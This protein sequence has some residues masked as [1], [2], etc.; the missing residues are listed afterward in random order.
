M[1]FDEYRK[2][3]LKVNDKDKFDIRNSY[4]TR[5][6]YRWCIKNRKI[7]RNISER[8]F[9]TIINTINQAIADEILKGRIVKLPVS[10][11]R[12][13]LAKEEK[14][15]RVK[16]DG[17]LTFMPINWYETLKLW[18]ED[19]EAEKNKTLV[20]FEVKEV[21]EI[22]YDVRKAKYNNKTYFKFTPMR[23]LKLRLKKEAN[24][25]NIDALLKYRNYGIHKCR[26]SNGQ[27]H[28]TPSSEGHAL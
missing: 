12:L 26:K 1:R 13:F 10:M 17:N 22:Y 9:R 18:H 23:D 28:K 21:Y 8:D 16:E 4:G 19:E 6:I 3:V 24:N 11:G 20:K 2:K 5:D 7:D 27:N 14:E 15:M 25:N